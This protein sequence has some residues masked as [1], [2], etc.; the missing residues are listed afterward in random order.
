[1]KIP[2]RTLLA[3]LAVAIAAALA[4]PAQA[5][6]EARIGGHGHVYTISNDAA[7]NALL[8]YTRGSGGA[9][10]L[11]QTVPTGGNGTGA[12]LGTQGAVTL[13][14]DGRYLFAVNAGSG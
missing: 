6:T 14:R 12:G 11:T 13:S 10:A 2:R 7:G 8:V 3:P 5:D 9:L 1:M 4:G